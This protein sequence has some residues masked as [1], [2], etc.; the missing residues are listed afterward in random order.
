MRL[1]VEGHC[2]HRIHLTSPALTRSELPPWFQIQCPQHQTVGMYWAST[3][4][5][6]PDAGQTTGGA[7]I[8]GL[9]GLLGGPIGL[10]LGGAAGALLGAANE[11][12]EQ[13][14]ANTFNQ[15]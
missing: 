6:Q 15:S 2:G 12:N 11:T 13:A 4:F 10:I 9:V 3:V 8:G 1:Y 14:R 7:V 5:A